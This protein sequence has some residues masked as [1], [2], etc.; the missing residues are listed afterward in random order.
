MTKKFVRL[1]YEKED[2][3]IRGIMSSILMHLHY[4]NPDAALDESRKLAIHCFKEADRIYKWSDQFACA[5]QEPEYLE[6]AK[7]LAS[8]GDIIEDMYW[9]IKEEVKV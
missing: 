8:C 3:Y 4:G 7:L 2:N 9:S 1:M 6:Y 5:D